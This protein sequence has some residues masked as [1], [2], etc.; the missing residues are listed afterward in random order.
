MLH[1]TSQFVKIKNVTLSASG[2]VISVST[3]I[4]RRRLNPLAMEW[5]AEAAVGYPIFRDS[6]AMFLTP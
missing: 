5:G 2:K 1:V 6:A 4:A 3:A